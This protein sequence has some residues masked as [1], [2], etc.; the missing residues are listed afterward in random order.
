MEQGLSS[1]NQ[2]EF[3]WRL[4]CDVLHADGE[5]APLRRGILLPALL[6]FPIGKIV[7]DQ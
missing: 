7:T 5:N 3:L 1:G 2:Q 6:R 4:S